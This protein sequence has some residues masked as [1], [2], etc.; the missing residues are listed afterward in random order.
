[1]NKMF[2]NWLQALGPQACA[3]IFTVSSSIMSTQ[4]LA[5]E[6][7]AGDYEYLPEG[8]TV[9]LQYFQYADRSKTYAGGNKA[10]SDFDLESTVGLTRF[11]R[12]IAV[13]DNIAVDLNLIVPYGRL[14]GSKNAAFLGESSGVG[15]LIVGVATKFL[16]DPESRNVFSIGTFA[17][18]PTGS[19]DHNRALN[20]GENRWKGL[21]QLVYI[22]HFNDRWALDVAGDVQFHGANDTFGNMKAKMKQDPRFEFQTHLSY[23]VSQQTAL[24]FG[25][26]RILGAETEV[27]GSKQNDELDTTYARFGVNHWINQTSQ[28][29]FQLGR[30]LSV[31]SGPMEDTR[32]NLRFAKLF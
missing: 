2:N 31:E 20:L 29:Q 7:T 4:V 1:M 21:V 9:A 25:L 22:K 18:L 17:H 8:A 16:L 13:K 24:T 19:Y 28:I 26:G 12:S 23:N 15:D 10:V 11:I 30:D 32:L 3:L 27:S 5:L 14:E 6:I